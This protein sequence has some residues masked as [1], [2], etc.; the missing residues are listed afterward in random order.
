MLSLYLSAPVFALGIV[1]RLCISVESPAGSKTL[2]QSSP[3][4]F[5]P[6][7]RHVLAPLSFPAP[8][9]LLLFSGFFSH[10]QPPS[11]EILR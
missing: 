8:S 7:S 10:L 2:V 5:T 3:G 1:S 4:K 11:W 9:T 6:Y